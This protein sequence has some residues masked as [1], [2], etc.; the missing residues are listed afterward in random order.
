MLIVTILTTLFASCGGGGNNISEVKLIPVKSG[1]DFQYIDQEGKISINPQFNQATVFRNSLALVQ[2]SGTEPKWGYISED[3]KFSIMANY[4]SATVFSDDLAWVISTNAAPT[5]IN[6]KGEIKFTLQEAQTVRIF[7]EGLAAYS[8][9]DSIGLKWGLVDKAG[10]V[11]INPQFSGLGNF[12]NGKCAVLNSEGKWGYI[13]KEGKI[14]I[15]YQFDLAKEFINGRAVVVN[16]GKAGVIDENGKYIINPQFTD[17]MSDGDVFLISQDGKWGWCDKDGKIT[18]NPQFGQA[19]PF[20]GNSLAAVLSGKSWGYIDTEGK[21]AVNPQFDYA[22]PF[23]GKLALVQSAGKVG[24]IDKEGKYVINPQFD[25]VSRDL[26]VYML[27]GSSEFE[28][29][30]TDFFN[31]GAISSKFNLNSPEGLNIG[32]PISKVVSNFSKTENDFN[33]YSTEHLILNNQKIERDAI[34]NFYVYANPYKDVPDGWYTQKVFDPTASIKAFAYTIS[35][36]GK[37]AGKEKEVRDAI[38]KS[39]TGYT[40][41]ATLSNEQTSSFVN[42]KQTIKISLNGSMLAIVISAIVDE[43]AMAEQ[44]D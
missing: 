17:M 33:K 12:N 3:G 36:Y 21:I 26:I 38:E 4:K 6:S 13:D 20:L 15:N 34:Y 10:K 14:V 16:G 2:S 30:E 28:S 11:K 44:G 43:T 5:A 19:F 8:V 27:N 22:L 37:G 1:K 42:G 40:K 18:I 35:L 32:D 39:L 41:D 7:K 25:D 31:I 29:V 24:F 9:N 23:N